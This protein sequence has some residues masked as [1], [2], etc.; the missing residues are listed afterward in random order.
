M[1][2]HSRNTRF[3]ITHE[4]VNIHD[5]IKEC[6]ADVKF[7]PGAESVIFQVDIPPQRTVPSDPRRLKIIFD[8]LISNAIKYRDPDKETNIIQIG[9]ENAKK[10]WQLEIYDNGIGIQ[11][12]HLGRLFEMFFRA[13]NRS[14]GS[15]LGLYIVHE[16]VNRLY[17]EVHVESE[18]G[19]WTRFVVTIPHDE[20]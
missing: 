3:E 2:Q 17:G 18:F 20:E 6:I 14:Q 15:G 19:A 10:F 13:T 1:I 9:F 12:K 8:N 16:T 11:T 5:L 4:T 7:M